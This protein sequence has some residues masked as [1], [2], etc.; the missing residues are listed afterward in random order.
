MPRLRRA[1]HGHPRR[2]PCWSPCPQSLRSFAGS[3]P[4][5]DVVP[6][7]LRQWLPLLVF[8]RG[9]FFEKA[10]ASGPAGAKRSEEWRAICLQIVRRYR[11][12]P[13]G[14]MPATEYTARACQ[15]GSNPCPAR[16]RRG[17]RALLF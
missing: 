15:D 4:L 6:H 2:G 1:A 3:T 12:R 9:E 16:R 8:Q 14:G 10:L 7:C 11:N 17:K 13:E 5:G